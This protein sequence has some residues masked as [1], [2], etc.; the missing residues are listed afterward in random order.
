MKEEKYNGLSTAE[1]E[2]LT[3]QGKV[4][5][6]DNNNLKSNWQI[7]KDNVFTLFNLY[8]LIIAIAL[9]LVGA[10]TNTFFFLIIT[11]NVLI[12]IIQEIHGKNLVKKL[13]ILT[14]SKTTVI[15][16][17]KAQEIEIEKVVLGDTIIFHNLNNL[18]D[19]ISVTVLA[20]LRY[21]SFADFFKDFDYK[22]CGTA[23]SLE[24]KLK[25]VHTFYTLEQE[26]ENG[27]LAIKI[28]LI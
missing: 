6:S 18:N 5:V 19:T 27:I 7:V 22:L 12:G 17:G 25:R 20:L 2:E 26:Q 15:R 10:Y 24:D 21:P 16:D 8:N 11:I 3:S 23:N 4:N 9:L 14:A 28:Q 13:S 1:V